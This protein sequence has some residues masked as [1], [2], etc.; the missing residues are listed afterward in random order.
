MWNDDF[1]HSAMVALSGHNEAYYTDYLGKPQEFISA[2]KYGFLYQGQRYDWQEMRRGSSTRGISPA[3]F[4][5]FIQNHDQVANSARGW[6]CHLISSPGRCRALTALM[7]LM[8]GTP[9]LFQGQEFHASRPFHFF[10][11]HHEE[12]ARK[13]DAGRKEFMEQFPSVAVPEMQARLPN[14]ADRATFLRC[15]LDF[16]EREKHAEAYAL[17]GDLLKLRR[18]DPV[19]SAQRAGGLDGAVLGEEAF[20]LRYFAEEERDGDERLLIVNLG[21][22][23]KLIPVPEPLLAPPAGFG[24]KVLWSS[25]D[26]RYGGGGTV[27]VESDEGWRLP[28]QAAVVLSPVKL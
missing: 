25:E 19:F 12:L 26:Y 3:A 2:A 8:P 13:V 4:I 28:G 27:A 20:V 18:E 6:R 21:R 9:M 15:K 11:D 14:P 7:L 22:D 17:H 10:A 5:T 23:L 1:H 16:A 24:W